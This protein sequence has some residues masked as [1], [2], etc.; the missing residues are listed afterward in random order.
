MFKEGQAVWV[1]LSVDFVEAALVAYGESFCCVQYPDSKLK[2]GYNSIVETCKIYAKAKTIRIG[3]FDVPEPLREAP[4]DGT[5]IY[6][7]TLLYCTLEPSKEVWRGSD[8]QYKALKAG[9]L[10]LTKE[11]AFLQADAMLS[12]LKE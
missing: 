6:F 8:Y 4:P 1:D 12:E 2:K 9:L 10:Q 5:I 3:E 7:V 11:A